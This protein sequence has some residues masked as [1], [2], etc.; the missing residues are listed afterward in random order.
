MVALSGTAR[1]QGSFG[2]GLINRIT[3]D[4]TN[5]FL[6][7]HATFFT[8]ADGMLQL[9]KLGVPKFENIFFIFP[10][11]IV[12]IHDRVLGEMREQDGACR[13]SGQRMGISWWAINEG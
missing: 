13:I 1:E 4:F 2:G 10:R 3:R 7:D 9:G 12:K 5:L 11:G 8:G 6:Q